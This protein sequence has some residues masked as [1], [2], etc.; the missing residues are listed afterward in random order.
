MY[1][2]ATLLEI[3]H[4]FQLVGGAYSSRDFDPATVQVK[5]IGAVYPHPGINI[6]FFNTINNN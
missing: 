6:N 2:E 5:Y 4:F 3:N 1:K